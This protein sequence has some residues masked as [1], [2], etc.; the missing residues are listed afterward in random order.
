MTPEGQPPRE[1]E[2]R[3][4]S[5]QMALSLAAVICTAMLCITWIIVT[6]I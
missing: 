4:V 3:E 2:A 5:W 6:L 1:R